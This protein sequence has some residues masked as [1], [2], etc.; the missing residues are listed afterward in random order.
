MLFAVSSRSAALPLAE[1]TAA[2]VLK[3]WAASTSTASIGLCRSKTSSAPIITGNHF[4]CLRRLASR[5]SS[6]EL[7]VPGK[8]VKKRQTDR[9]DNKISHAICGAQSWPRTRIVAPSKS[10]L[11]RS[12]GSRGSLGSQIL[13]YYLRIS[14]SLCPSSCGVSLTPHAPIVTPNSGIT[15]AEYHASLRNF[16]RGLPEPKGE[17]PTPVVRKR[18]EAKH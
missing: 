4:F 6:V 16:P 18:W 9:S 1:S 11:R 15:D 13:K 12:S 2:S 8:H 14:K 10:T 7:P 3:T 5:F 17:L